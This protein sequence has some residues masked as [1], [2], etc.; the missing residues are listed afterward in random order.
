MPAIAHGEM[1]WYH[2]CKMGIAHS[3]VRYDMESN[4]MFVNKLAWVLSSLA[5]KPRLGYVYPN[6]L[7]LGRAS[8]LTESSTSAQPE[9]CLAVT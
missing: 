4:S 6:H 2:G 7:N 5:P 8:K 9:A 1:N 3:Q